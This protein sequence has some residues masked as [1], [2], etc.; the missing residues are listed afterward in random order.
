MAKITG[1]VFNEVAFNNCKMLGL[2]FEQ[3]SSFGLSMSFAHCIMDHCSFYQVKLKKT[4]FQNCQIHEADFT[5]AD[6]N[7]AI[8]Q[9]CDL[10][11]SVFFQCNLEK[12]DFRSATNYAINL[13]QNKVKKTRFSYDGLAGL[14]S[15]YDIVI[16]R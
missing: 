7:A 9:E 8:F 11:G 2:G 13:E 10:L 15:Q 12:T 5:E 6:L 3:A 1:T 4:K 14:L 16:D